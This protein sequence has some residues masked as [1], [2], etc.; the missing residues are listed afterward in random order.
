MLR[1]LGDN[2]KLN[3]N[4]LMHLLSPYPQHRSALTDATKLAASGFSARKEIVIFGYEDEG[5]PLELA[6]EA[7]EVLARN[8]VTLGPRLEA[9]FGD[10]IHPVHR[11]G[12]V[13][14]W[15]IHKEFS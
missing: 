14:A 11:S 7:F 13:F 1:L 15:E 4:M 3:D 12:G 5:W 6:V 10:L 2:G 9:I 8:A